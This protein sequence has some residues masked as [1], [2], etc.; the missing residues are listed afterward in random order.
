MAVAVAIRSLHI[1]ISLMSR[2]KRFLD[3]F[4]PKD[5]SA[6]LWRKYQFQR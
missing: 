5:W 3:A 1:A 4:I 2:L 6:V